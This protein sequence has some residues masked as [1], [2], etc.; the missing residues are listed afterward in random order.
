M[1]RLIKKSDSMRI[2]E[3]RQKEV[4]NIC[5]GARLGIVCDIEFNL[6]T[7][8][9]TH[10]VVAGPCRFLGILGRE[11]EYVIDLCHIKQIGED[12]ILVEVNVEKCIVKCKF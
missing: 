2:C 4:I 8:C 10:I 7:G 5:D 12:V 3:L 6:C 1:H 9:I 11:S